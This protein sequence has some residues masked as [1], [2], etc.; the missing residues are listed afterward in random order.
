LRVSRLTPQKRLTGRF[1]KF[2]RRLRLRVGTSIAVFP[3]NKAKGRK[4]GSF[5]GNL[6]NRFAIW[7]S[8]RLRNDKGR[9]EA[10]V[11]KL[12]NFE[13]ASG[14]NQALTVKDAGAGRKSELCENKKEVRPGGLG[15]D[16]AT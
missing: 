16:V 10:P 2:H 1:Q 7:I 13:T 3:L 8:Q 11:A 6:Q 14:M 15:S 4:N 5:G 12:N 9:Q